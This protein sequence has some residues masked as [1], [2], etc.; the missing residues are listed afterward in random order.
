VLELGGGA[1]AVGILIAVYSLAP[2]I[3][4]LPAGRAVD[5]NGA[6]VI[7]RC[8]SPAAPNCD[9]NLLR[10]FTF[11]PVLGPIVMGIADALLGAR[12]SC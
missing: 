2:L 4:A 7:L 6:A 10:G 5:N 8:A 9:L 12:E 3:C 11:L 1:A